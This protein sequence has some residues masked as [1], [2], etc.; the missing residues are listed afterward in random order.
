MNLLHGPRALL[1]A[2]ALVAGA[3]ACGHG[4]PNAGVA[5]VRVTGPASALDPYAF[6]LC[7][8]TRM[9]QRPAR[10]LPHVGPYLQRV[11]ARPATQRVIATEKLSQPLI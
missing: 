7:R 9:G 11:L 2:C 3:P 10:A 4:V 8:W 5:R 6:M 1:L